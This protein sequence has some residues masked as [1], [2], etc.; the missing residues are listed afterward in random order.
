[1]HFDWWTLALQ[2]VNFAILVW[3]L[4]RFLYAP[5]L[6]VVDARKA[7]VQRQYAD[8]RAAGEEAAARLATIE[9]ERSALAD[10]RRKTLESAAAQAQE[11]AAARRAQAERDARALAETTRRALATER[12][13]ALEEA[14]R[15]A[16][17]LGAAFARRLLADIPA[18]LRA[19]AWLDRIEQ[20]LGVLP[21]A[22]RDA[23]ARQLASGA[24]LTVITATPLTADTAET[25]RTRLRS[26]LGG[27]IAIGFEADARL[28]AG[29][30]LHFPTAI[31]QLSWRSALEAAC[32]E[33][34]TEVGAQADAQAGAQTDKRDDAQTGA[35]GSSD[36]Q[37]R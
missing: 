6:R 24:P 2:T 11:A 30:E 4:H 5:V 26:L 15:L 25:W 33:I 31:L 36:G 27:D 8:A 3:L 18:P 32:A 9:A 35:K 21:Q 1:M 17:D 23:L 10:E 20:H 37:P 29:A 14:R 34:D 19:E 7:E 16:L 13:R 28:I 12:T 22:Q